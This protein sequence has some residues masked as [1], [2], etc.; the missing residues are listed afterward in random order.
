MKDHRKTRLAVLVV[1]C[2][3]GATGC[4]R[5]FFRESADRE[6]NDILKEK[7]KYPDW[8]IE[9]YHVYPDARARFADPTNPDRPP[10]PPD[11]EA[12]WKLGPHPQKP[13][14]KGPEG[15]E[16]TG[17]VE[18]LKLWDEQN[19]TELK[20]VNKAKQPIRT[21]FDEPLASERKGFL[22]K[23]DQSI[24]LG[25]INSPTYQTFREGLYEATLPVTLARYNFAYQWAAGSDW[26]RQYAGPLS[27]VGPENNWTGTS[28]IGFSKLFVTGA[29]LTTDFV[30][31]T[32]F[33][34]GA[35]PGLFSSSIFNL[36]FTQPLLQGGG[37]A[38]TLEP[39][40]LA[41]RNLIYSI[42]AYARFR[43]QFNIAVALGTTPPG[44]L[45]AA[46]GLSITN[47]ISI[48]AALNIA[49]TDVSGGFVGYLST[50][51]R[52]CDMAV[53]KKLVQD[54][55]RALQII[56]AYQE[57]GMFSPLQVEQ[58][59]STLL[60]AQNGVLTDEQ[61][62]TNALDQ[63]K[64]VLG[65]P[66]NMP[67]I[68]DDTAA[69]P[70]TVIF[71]RYYELIDDALE[72][73]MLVD[74]QESVPAQKLRAKLQDIFADVPLV[75]GT[76]FQ[77]VVPVSWGKWAKSSDKEIKK[78]LES[79]AETYRKLLNLKTDLELQGKTL[80]PEDE[81]AM[82]D[83]HFETDLGV[84]EL[85]LREYEAMP[86]EKAA[87]KEL[88]ELQRV[89]SYRAVAAQ[90]KTVLVWARNDR[91]AG[92]LKMWPD[93]PEAIIEGIDMINEDV[94]IAQEKAVQAAL[95]NRWDLM[96]VRAQ[97]VDA[98]RQ[99]RVT[100][101]ALLAVANVG[102]NLSSQ[103]PPD[104]THPLAFSAASTNQQLFFNWQLPLN[105]VA[106][107]NA[108]RTALINYQVARRAQMIQEDNIAAQVRFDVR[109]LRLFVANYIIQ[110]KV[111]HSLYS[112]LEN[113]LEVIVSP[114]DPD[115]LKVS[116][117]T[118]QA[119]AAALTS[120]YLT[121][122]SSLNGSQT[123]MY[124]VWLSMYATRMQIYLDL[125]RLLMDERGV[126]TDET[127][128]AGGSTPQA[129]Q[130]MVPPPP[131]DLGQAIETPMIGTPTVAI[132]AP[133]ATAAPKAGAPQPNPEPRS[134]GLPSGTTAPRTIPLPFGDDAVT[135]ASAEI[136]AAPGS[137]PSF[138]APQPVSAPR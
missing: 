48:L 109:Q 12:S 17:Y 38:V 106:Q 71:D 90:A 3:A 89:K 73:Q 135:P 60:N 77:K 101:N 20:P 138:L 35:G 5:N 25:V 91:F 107:R 68:L 63:F 46:V 114:T 8:K 92:T 94:D 55:K 132:T 129:Q 104:G 76:E 79:L 86:W 37:K 75:R 84:L 112:Q 39:L 117:T 119:T 47:P 18:M 6:V 14:H 19:R 40:A 97:V 99:I 13:K 61:F 93:I 81:L 126:W 56:E 23:M 78:R 136:P 128:K 83:A 44:D 111:M 123:R 95:R 49:S 134:P 45:P 50:L 11:D 57:G 41:E 130:T 22:L 125:E 122:L 69:R 26:V 36:N 65:V 24:E 2:L 103:T 88:A 31:T 96:N 80:S 85:K 30:N 9:Q 98:W 70:V 113:N 58:V 53:D 131:V 66:V 29:L 43:E 15:V 87:K 64:I 118:G 127:L 28:N 115:Q 21:F 72:A 100:A 137:R 108:Y 120:Q 59:R 51:Y 27:D 54:L 32:A 1:L 62:V 82:R 110:K 7:D 16:G 105:R 116:S 52:E 74:Q 34:F 4:T 121:A 10:M 67:L 33:N 102:Y 124:D 133:P 42:R